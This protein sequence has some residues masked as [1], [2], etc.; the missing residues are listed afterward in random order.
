MAEL[1][2][3]QRKRQMSELQ[4]VELEP[5]VLHSA[6]LPMAVLGNVPTTDD[7]QAVL[8]SDD[9]VLSATGSEGGT[10]QFRRASGSQ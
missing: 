5:R 9:G 3:R 6:D 8:L 2:G 4:F 10:L 7:A 1:S